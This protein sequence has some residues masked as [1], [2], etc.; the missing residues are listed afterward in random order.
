M[1]TKLTDEYEGKNYETKNELRLLQQQ[2]VNVV[3]GKGMTRLKTSKNNKATKRRM[4]QI[5][6][7]E[8]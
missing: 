3:S 6:N 4:L 7:E 5:I 1:P 2:Q 8:K